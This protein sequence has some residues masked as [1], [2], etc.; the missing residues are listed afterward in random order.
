MSE[1]YPFKSDRTL[2]PQEHIIWND[3]E[4]ST[5]PSMPQFSIT[6]NALGENECFVTSEGTE[7]LTEL[8]NTNDI[9]F[10]DLHN[11]ALEQPENVQFE[12]ID[13][14]NQDLQNQVI[15]FKVDGS[16]EL[17]GMQMVQDEHGNIEKYQFKF[18]TNESGELEAIPDTIQLIPS[19]DSERREEVILEEQTE[20]VEQTEPELNI[21]VENSEINMQAGEIQ[22][23]PEDTFDE[24]VETPHDLEEETETDISATSRIRNVKEEI[25][26]EESCPL[27]E[28]E[29]LNCK[30]E[31]EHLIEYHETEEYF[32]N[33]DSNENEVN[34]NAE[35]N[36]FSEYQEIYI[37][38]PSSGNLEAGMEM[39]HLEEN[40][41]EMMEDESENEYQI[42]EGMPVTAE[43]EP[44]QP[45]HGTDTILQTVLEQPSNANIIKQYNSKVDAEGNKV[46]YFIVQPVQEKEN[47]NNSVYKPAKA[48]PRSILKTS[49]VPPAPVDLP[50][51]DEKMDKRFA[52]S[53][54]AIQAR[55]FHNF[56]TKTTIPHAP[57]RSERLPRKQKIKPV[58]DRIDEEIIVQEV[59][60]SSSGVIE[61]LDNPRNR[62]DNVT[63]TEY[64]ELTDS[65][66]DR[67][68]FS[69]SDDSVIEIF[70]S[71]DEVETQRKRGRPRKSTSVKKKR[72]RPILDRSTVMHADEV[73]CPR[74]PKTF[75]N[76]NSLNT[77][78][79]HH[80]LETS[81]LNSKSKNAVLEYKHKCDKCQSTFKNTIL[82]KKHVCTEPANDLVCPI[83]KKKFSIVTMF[84]LHKRIHVKE[85]VLKLTSPLRIS[86][87]KAKATITKNATF[88][89]SDCP[90]YFKSKDLLSDHSKIHK[91]F[92]C[93]SCAKFFSSRIL[94]DTHV[95]EKCV[96][97]K[98]SPQNRRLSF[99]TRTSLTKRRSSLFRPKKLNTAKTNSSL[100]NTPSSSNKQT[101]IDCESCPMKFSSHKQLFTHKV[102]K[103]GQDTPD[104]SILV[105]KSRKSLYKPVSTHGGIPVND[106]LRKAYAG[107]KQKLECSQNP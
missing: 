10:G 13:E 85:H 82:L 56:I 97:F 6:T 53:K 39:D 47:V 52:K 95:R 87:N 99:K 12:S 73:K 76:Q 26:T 60:V 78:I 59:M 103:H 46:T 33:E 14:A 9:A 104:K 11:I 7:Y 62:R 50:E 79:Q 22:S 48:N 43:A 19:D 63:V 40:E 25:I 69:E 28:N 81:L 49:Y 72:G 102:V 58:N 67:N 23:E 31:N 37:N 68:R 20:G 54:E 29:A 55:Q 101:K 92:C 83:C 71:D 24:T 27:D 15:V 51:Y 94:L 90:K 93:S 96:K 45:M 61:T 88:K 2:I 42:I 70:N 64:V 106:R 80:N 66:D 107:L 89:C 5:R 86:Q 77:H 4:T 100:L 21:F 32:Q 74:C 17:Y 8:E 16:D 75:P 34:E 41:L 44:I 84:N 38:E 105:S 98:P 36:H 3:G 30:Q 65:D 35:E 1:C 91:K 57:V 18:G